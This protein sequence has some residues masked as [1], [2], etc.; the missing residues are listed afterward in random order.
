MLRSR[1]RKTTSSSPPLTPSTRLSLLSPKRQEIVRLALERPREFV[2]LSVRAMAE[3]LKTD[4]AT[5]VRIVRGMQFASYR[6]F[7]HY[8][9]ELSLASATS[10][11]TMQ[12]HIEGKFTLS[13]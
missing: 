12:I 4:P 6:D 7:Q 5:M 8:L 10:L 13:K 1:K 2:L 3:R 9:H 11:D